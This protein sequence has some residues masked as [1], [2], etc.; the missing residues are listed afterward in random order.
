MHV[1]YGGSK[2]LQNTPKTL[3]Y[4]Q[5]RVYHSISDNF[6]LLVIAMTLAEC[7]KLCGKRYVAAGGG[8]W[9]ND[10]DVMWQQQSR[11]D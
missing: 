4:M 6:L 11:H 1:A 7:Y 5:N 8:M 10:I 9:P 3:Y 2:G